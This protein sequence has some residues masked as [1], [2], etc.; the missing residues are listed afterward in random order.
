MNGKVL[1]I[2][3]AQ[4]EGEPMRE[5]E[6]VG[7]VEYAGLEGDRYAGLRGAFSRSGRKVIRHISII[8]KEAIE[9]ANENRDAPFEPTDTRRNIVVS[10]IRLNALVGKEFFIGKIRMKGVELC[11]PCDRPSKL[12][13]KPGFKEAFA[14]FGGLRAEVLTSG[15]MKVGDAI[16]AATFSCQ[17]CGYTSLYPHICPA[18]YKELDLQT[19][20]ILYRTGK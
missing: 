5:V 16:E 7:V 2:C 4:D 14:G 20:G 12:C 10:G 13:G 18:F 9:R 8:E 17:L 15:V 6:E 1:H 3:I 19:L 11:E